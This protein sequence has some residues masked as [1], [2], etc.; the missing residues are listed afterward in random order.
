MTKWNAKPKL[1]CNFCMTPGLIIFILYQLLI[2][3][4]QV[5][6]SDHNVLCFDLISM[7]SKA[8]FLDADDVQIKS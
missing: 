8:N 6:L 1:E 7:C 5:D 3:I 2:H 4:F